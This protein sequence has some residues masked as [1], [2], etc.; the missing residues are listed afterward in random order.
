MQRL[1]RTRHVA[2]LL[3]HRL[4]LSVRLLPL[5]LLVIDRDEAAIGAGCHFSDHSAGDLGC[6]FGDGAGVAGGVGGVAAGVGVAAGGDEEGE[7]EEPGEEGV[8]VCVIYGGK[9]RRRK[10]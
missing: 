10:G 8:L 2:L 7:V 4:L 5:H 6:F 1:R 3:L 9:G